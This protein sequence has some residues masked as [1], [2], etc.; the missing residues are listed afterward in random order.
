MYLLNLA[1]EEVLAT[2][3]DPSPYGKPSVHAR[4]AAELDPNGP[5]TLRRVSE[6]LAAVRQLGAALDYARRASELRPDE[7]ALTTGSR[8]C[9]AMP[10]VP[11][12][13]RTS[14]ACRVRAQASPPAAQRGRVA[15]ACSLPPRRLYELTPHRVRP[16]TLLTTSPMVCRCLTVPGVEYDGRG[17]VTIQLPAFAAPPRPGAVIVVRDVVNVLGQT[18]EPDPPSVALP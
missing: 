3:S 10:V 16:S 17:T 8:S 18:V 13:R 12:R 14:R 7:P 5:V 11:R 6:I 15:S 1:A 2:G 4:H 9:S